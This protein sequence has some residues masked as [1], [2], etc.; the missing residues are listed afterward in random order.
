MLFLGPT[1]FSGDLVECGHVPL[2]VIQ[3]IIICSIYIHGKCICIYRSYTYLGVGFKHFLF[4]PL[5]G[6]M[7]QFD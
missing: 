2:V 4:S 6:E 7:I 5:P 1:I 3:Y